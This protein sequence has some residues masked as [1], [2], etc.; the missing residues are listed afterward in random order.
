MYGHK[1]NDLL[2]ND[3]VYRKLNTKPLP[4]M[5]SNFNLDLSTIVNN[6][7][8]ELDENFKKRFIIIVLNSQEG[9][10]ITSHNFKL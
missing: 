7:N 3:K 4:K 2:S 9:C 6:F 1:M 8:K 10:T 5:Q